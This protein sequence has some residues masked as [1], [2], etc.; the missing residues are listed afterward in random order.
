MPPPGGYLLDTNILVHLVRMDDLGRYLDSTY[1]L[2]GGSNRF[3]VSIV[4]WG[5]LKALAIGFGWGPARRADMLVMLGGFREADINDPSV[6]DAYADIDAW[7]RATGCKM[8]KNDLWI[9]A[10]ALVTGT[11]LLTTDKDFDHLHDPDP[12]RS[13]RVDR[14]RAARP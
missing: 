2:S 14:V 9:A 12:G 5:E 1:S 7:S 13:W 8:G 4:T 10:T 11:T 3:I 6:L